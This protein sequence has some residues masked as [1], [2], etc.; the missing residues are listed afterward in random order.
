MVAE[1]ARKRKVAAALALCKPGEIVR[2]DGCD[3]YVLHDEV[4]GYCDGRSFCPDCD[5]PEKWYSKFSKRNP[6]VRFYVYFDPLLSTKSSYVQWNHPT[7]G[8]PFFV[9]DA[10][11]AH[12]GQ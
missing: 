12:K 7:P 1:K 2:C 9:S 11:G 3:G 5:L 10:V 4:H 8:N 6:G